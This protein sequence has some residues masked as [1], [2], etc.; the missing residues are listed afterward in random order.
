MRLTDRET[1]EVIMIRLKMYVSIYM[2]IISHD[3][4]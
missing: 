1:G 3:P 4:L 2:D